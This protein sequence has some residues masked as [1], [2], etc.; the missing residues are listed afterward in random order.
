MEISKDQLKKYAGLLEDWIPKGASIAIAVRGEYV[1]YVAGSQDLQLQKGQKVK[2]GSI[3]EIVMQT[4]CRTEGVVEDKILNVPY[5]GIAYP[6]DILGESGALVVILPPNYSLVHQPPYR[7]LTGKQEEEWRP[8]PIEKIAYMES[9]QKKT[10]FYAGKEPY[11]TNIPLK[12]LQQRLPESFL[13]I[14]RSYIV[15]VSFIDSIIRD[16]SS[17]L[18]VLLQDGTELPVSQTYTAD[19]RNALGF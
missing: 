15:N 17:N 11:K 10:W 3:A 18:L 4:C 5:Y 6:I 16:F 19:I 14:H 2:E 8:I 7:F 13:R 1:Y 12:E 9:L